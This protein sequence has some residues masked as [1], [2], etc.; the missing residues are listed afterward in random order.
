MKKK[1]PFSCP[2]CSSELSV[3]SLSCSN[4]DTIVSGKFSLPV[5]C[6]LNEDDQV[7]VLD[8]IKSS[9]SLKLMAEKLKLSYPSV[10]NKLDDIIEHLNSLQKSEQ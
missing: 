9:G 6:Q 1:L 8:F 4:C 5:L 3:Q 10:R 7:F 2:S